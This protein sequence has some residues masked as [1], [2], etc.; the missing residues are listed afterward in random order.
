MPKLVNGVIV[1]LVAAG[2]VLAF[3]GTHTLR[4]SPP[5]APPKWEA[6]SHSRTPTPPARKAPAGRHAAVPT[7]RVAGNRY[8]ET[9]MARSVPL[10]VWI[11]HIKVRAEIISL[12]LTSGGAVGVPSLSTPFLTSWYNKG[13][14]PGAPGAAVIFGHVDSAAVGPAVFY[15]LGNLRPGDL[16][17]KSVV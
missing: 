16:D 11:P 7:V 4:W 12:G 10:S 14:T 5:A 8:Q 15:R 3:V 1:A 2:L 17:R 9:P 13:P 6:S